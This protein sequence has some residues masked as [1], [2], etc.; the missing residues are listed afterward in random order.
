MKL[1]K[2]ITHNFRSFYGMHEVVF[3]DGDEKRVTI[4]HGENGSGKTTLLNA[5]YWC[6]TGRFTPRFSESQFVINKDAFR[7]G[8][9][10][11]SVELYFTGEVKSAGD[12]VVYRA[13]RTGQNQNRSSPLKIFK[14]VEGNSVD[15]E[16]GEAF[17]RKLIPDSLVD[18]FFFDAEAIGSLE[19]SGS[20]DFKKDLNRTLGFEMIQNL[21]EDLDVL[22]S[23]KQ[24][25]ISSAVKNKDLEAVQK[26]IENNSRDLPGIDDLIQATQ[27]KL[28]E[29]QSSLTKISARLRDLPKSEPLVRERDRLLSEVKFLKVEIEKMQQDVRQ[30]VGESAPSILLAQVADSLKAS[31]KVKEEKARL[32]SPYSDVLVNEIIDEEMCLCG[33]EVKRD[34]REAEA[35]RGLLKFATTGELTRRVSQLQYFATD[36]TNYSERFVVQEEKLS[37]AIASKQ[38]QLALKEERI[39]EIHEELKK[40][41]SAEIVQLEKENANLD[42]IRLQKSRELGGYQSK[43]E[44]IVNRLTQA[45]AKFD[46][47]KRRI[48]V[49]VVLEK[50][51]N[52]VKKIIN[53]LTLKLEQQQTQTIRILSVELNLVLRHFLVKNFTARIDPNSYA[54]KMYDDL[55]R[56]VPP[57][58]G[59]GQV[60]KF[61]FIAAV[62]A[63]AA[64]KTQNKIDWLSEPTI[65]PLMLDAPFSALDPTYQGSVASNL[66]KQSMQLILMLS[67]GAWGKSVS[68]ALDPHVGKRYLIVSKERVERGDKPV[69]TVT[70]KG[71]EYQLNH[72]GC[73]REESV[74]VEVQE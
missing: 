27:A 65:A 26:E 71:R 18:W 7:D 35:L 1:V 11:C 17:L 69:K 43:K 64:K 50:E 33:R 70:I 21:L 51:L 29:T 72:Y 4:F 53:F 23:R 3:A 15:E 5:V 68:D 61:A 31:L 10:D 12:R 55:D 60:L 22:K 52:K 37:S 8:V 38:S 24:K 41:E 42:Q 62:V 25:E 28:D 36:L 16:L 44:L 19:L 49:S 47:L 48:G 73:D 34:S 54:V 13:I 63:L 56:E 74:F 9:R 57:S 32:P 2:L 58:T 66:A 45:N 67:S 20:L 40:I 59:E 46:N 14:I 39:Q 6:I 30:L